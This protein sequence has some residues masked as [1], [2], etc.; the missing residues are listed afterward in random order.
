MHACHTE[1]VTC[2][3]TIEAGI[4]EGKGVFQMHHLKVRT[5]AALWLQEWLAAFAANFVRWAAHWLATACPHTP[6]PLA[7]LCAGGVKEHV[8]VGAHTSAWVVWQAQGC[9]VTFSD[10]SVYAG[11][12]VTNGTWA[13]QPPL[14]LFQSW[15]FS[16]E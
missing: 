5:A 3:Y 15:Y 2:D 14:P 11:H 1:F 4:K 7:A 16:S 10:Q 6:T 9:L 13:F 8:T 12:T